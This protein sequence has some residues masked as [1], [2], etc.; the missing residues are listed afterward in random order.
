M[1]IRQSLRIA[2]S[3]DVEM[4][5]YVLAG[6]ELIP[7]HLAGYACDVI[8]HHLRSN[9]P[10]M[11]VSDEGEI[12]KEEKL[13]IL[14]MV[15]LFYFLDIFK[16]SD[17][18]DTFR[19]AWK[20]IVRWMQYFVGKYLK[21]HAEIESGNLI[22]S[23]AGTLYFASKMD[24]KLEK[25]ICTDFAMNKLVAS[26]WTSSYSGADSH[27]YASLVLTTALEYSPEV[28]ST[29]QNIL[30]LLCH[31]P[32]VVVSK[33]IEE[34]LVRARD[35]QR[36]NAYASLA[37]AFCTEATENMMYNMWKEDGV[38]EVCGV[39]KRCL[40]ESPPPGDTDYERACAAYA[41][42]VTF[43]IRMLDCIVGQAIVSHALVSDFLE[44]LA[45]VGPKFDSLRMQPIK[46]LVTRFLSE[47]LPRIIMR[48]EK[49]DGFLK[50]VGAAMIPGVKLVAMESS[51]ARDWTLLELFVRERAAYEVFYRRREDLGLIL[52][53]RA[54]ANVSQCFEHMCHDFIKGYT[55]VACMR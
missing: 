22:E 39:L 37:V 6:I 30:F 49:T 32:D 28:A 47:V 42:L 33:L 7:P 51:F 54:C 31:I 17:V 11:G 2:R 52:K 34:R 13:A 40:R 38:Y 15:T 18:I 20:S 27:G 8:C 55:I 45:L 16:T 44:S 46:R 21:Q 48:K 26:L 29:V 23:I 3:G 41:Q 9:P 24:K 1:A 12:T 35:F 25:S 50:A 19:L 14:S 10:P 53:P 4:M 43:V 5:Q 36:L